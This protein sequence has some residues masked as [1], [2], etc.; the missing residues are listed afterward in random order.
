[1][2]EQFYSLVTE[3]G[4]A[5]IANAAVLGEKV[6]ITHLA[7]GDSGGNYYEPT[8]TQTALVSEVWKGAVGTIKIDSVNKNWVVIETL[9][10]SNIG[11]FTIREAGLYDEAGDLLV[12]AKY[13]ATYKPIAEQGTIKELILRQIFEV[14]NA[15]SVTLKIDPAVTIATKK[16]LT[17]EINNIKILISGITKPKN[18]ETTFNPDGTITVQTKKDGST[19]STN[20]IEFLQD[21]R[22]TEHYQG[23]DDEYTKTTTFTGNKIYTTITR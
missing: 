10:P 15:E 7:V 21:G 19:D 2:A 5:K 9:I 23:T 4:K 11:G 1:M 16:E 8:E 13:P 17:E 22:I 6:K 3:I 14:S 12:I 18:A 20:H